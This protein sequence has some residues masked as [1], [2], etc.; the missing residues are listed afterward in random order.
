MPD[1]QVQVCKDWVY[2]TLFV[3]AIP[4]IFAGM[5]IKEIVLLVVTGILALFQ[6]RA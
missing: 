5:I 6:R 3:I 2:I 1:S 4:F